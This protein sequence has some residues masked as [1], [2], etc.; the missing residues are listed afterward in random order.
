[1]ISAPEQAQ[2]GYAM[3]FPWVSCLLVLAALIAFHFTLVPGAAST[4]T[5]TPSPT[6]ASTP[7]PSPSP[8]PYPQS[9][10]TIRFVRDGQPVSVT[11]AQSIGAISADGVQCGVR[12]LGVVVESSGYR[13]AWPLL[14]EPGQPSQCTKGPPTT[15]RFRFLGYRPQ[16]NDT[17]DLS[18]ELVWVGRD[19]TVD[20]EVPGAATPSATPS[21]VRALP[22]AGGAPES[23]NPGFTL[24]VIAVVLGTLLVLVPVAAW[25]YRKG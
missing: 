10:I 18:T 1:M 17:F 24:G 25:P 22:I 2:R 15:L 5:P 21:P 8:S 13:T 23:G 12:V 6:L 3:R 20:I 4:Y 19:V 14:A 9:T 7:T 16:F 11:L